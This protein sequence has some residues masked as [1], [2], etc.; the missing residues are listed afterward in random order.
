MN[1]ARLE[2]ATS[3]SASLR[4]DP[5]ELRVRREGWS[6]KDEGKRTPVSRAFILH[7]SAFIL[8]KAEAVRLER[9]GA[10][11]ARRLSGPLHY[12]LCV[13]SEVFNGRCGSR[14]HRSFRSDSFRDCL[15]CPCPTSHV[16]QGRPDSNRDWRIWSS[17]VWPLTYA[18]SC[19]HQG[20]LE[21]PC[22]T[23]GRRLYRPLPNRFGL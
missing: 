11:N 16:W 12:R 23:Q 8:S 21:P 3:S 9:T 5:S 22:P 10:T 1:P 20:G 4:S 2:L 7:P 19:M 18:P 6:R 15:A 17:P 14:T 13:A